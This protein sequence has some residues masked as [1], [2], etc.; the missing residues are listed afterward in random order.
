MAQKITSPF[1]FVIDTDRYAGNFE[2]MMCGYVTGRH[3]GTH[4][5]I[6]ISGFRLIETVVKQNE[7]RI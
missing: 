3:D 4:E 5:S 6:A 1:A 2:R 7:I